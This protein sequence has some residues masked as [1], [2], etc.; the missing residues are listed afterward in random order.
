MKRTALFLFLAM[1]AASLSAQFTNCKAAD[2]AKLKS[3]TLTVA[4]S[5]DES[6]NKE[7]ASILASSWKVSKFNI[8]KRSELETFVK[9]NPENFV[10]MYM[11]DNPT[12]VTYKASGSTRTFQVG[13][14][15]M[16]LE[17]VK[18][19]KRLKP[20]D[21]MAYSFIDHDLEEVSPAAELTREVA[22]IN[23]VMMLPNLN[24]KMLGGWKVATI[25]NKDILT[26]ELWIAETDLKEGT[27]QAD[28]KAAYSPGKFKIVSKEDISKAITEKKKGVAYVVPAEYQ[29]GA[30]MF[31]VHSADDGRA[32]FFMAGTKGFNQK[33]LVKIKENKTYGQ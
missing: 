4:L 29:A 25:N 14:M 28:M 15:L 1:N 22:Q 20:A 21:G 10:M 11:T 17:N 24:D 6:S 3:S 23:A 26:Q 31:L 16:I 9:A 8:I 13:D 7:V 27:D 19:I 32:L 30:Y 2:V 33:S 12:W 18:K 5:D